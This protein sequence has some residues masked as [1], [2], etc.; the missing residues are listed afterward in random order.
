MR[1]ARHLR[2]ELRRKLGFRPALSELDPYLAEKELVFEA[3]PFT[4][5]L[6]EVIRVLS[7]QFHLKPDEPSRRFWEL[8]QNG[9]CWGE[10]EA[11]QPFLEQL[12]KPSKV[13]DI[14]P[15]LGRS[16]VFFKK[17]LGLEKVPFHLYESSGSSSK[18]TKAGPR[19]DDSF[20]TDLDT[21]RLVLEHN[22]IEQYEIYDAALMDARLHGLAGPYDFL[23]S[24]FAIGFHWSISHFLEELLAL[25]HDRSIAAFTLHDR[26]EALDEVSHL[27]HRIVSARS[28]WPRDRHWR[29]LVLAKTEEALGS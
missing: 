8:N 28:S 20:C 11:I 9:L 6:V 12:G 10:Y 5:K 29:I 13:L 23:Y 24:F 25:M 22:G 14:G 1:A 3:P 17:K 19:F 18:Y 21:L 27:P 26:F 4:P 7:A 2:S 16:V 15:G